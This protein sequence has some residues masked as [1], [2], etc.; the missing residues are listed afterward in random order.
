MEW[1][2]TVSKSDVMYL[3]LMHLLKTVFSMHVLLGIAL[4]D[5][6]YQVDPE[7]LFL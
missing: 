3:C 4:S 6:M 1:L 2:N 7:Q 5:F